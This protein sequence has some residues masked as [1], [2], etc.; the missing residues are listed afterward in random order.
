MVD[1]PGSLFLTIFPR[2]RT[3]KICHQNFTTFFTVE[4]AINKGICHLVLTLGT[5]SCERRTFQRIMYEV[6][7]S[8]N[9]ESSF[10]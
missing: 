1:I 3:L 4:F 2:K 7:N 10:L 9:D 8:S 6:R 5:I